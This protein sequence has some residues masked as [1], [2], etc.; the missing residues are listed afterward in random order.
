MNVDSLKSL[1][2]C[3]EHLLL[4][5]DQEQSLNDFLA[6]SKGSLGIHG[7]NPE[8]KKATF[9][10]KM[11][12]DSELEEIKLKLKLVFDSLDYVSI[13]S[14]PKLKKFKPIVIVDKKNGYEGCFSLIMN[15]K[16]QFGIIREYN[17]TIELVN[18]F[19]QFRNLEEALIF[20]KKK[21]S[22]K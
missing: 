18:S 6:S 21:M 12:K 5:K 10:L 17:Q 19:S 2:Q 3:G 22:P 7:I 13:S 14:N 8:S 20:I 9:C 11:N 15:E 1:I 4:E 16:E